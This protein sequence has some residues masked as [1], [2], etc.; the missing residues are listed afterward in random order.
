MNNTGI[1]LDYDDPK[2]SGDINDFV[3]RIHVTVKWD[4]GATKEVKLE[5]IMTQK[6]IAGYTNSIEAWVDHRRTG[7]PKLPYNYKNDSNSDWGII[8]PNDFL[9][10]MP[11]VNS[12][13]ENN[14]EAVQEATGFL[15][16][17]DEIG[18]RLWW[19]TGGPNF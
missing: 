12:Q 17:P 5:K 6:W 7:Y 4:E 9:R 10:R 15:G 2:A 14:T 13:R 3:N 16:G 1:P 19:D 8:P 18:T 11:F